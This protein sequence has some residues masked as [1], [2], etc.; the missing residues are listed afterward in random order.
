LPNKAKKC[1]VFNG[2][3]WKVIQSVETIFTLREY[4]CSVLYHLWEVSAN[5]SPRYGEASEAGF[6]KCAAIIPR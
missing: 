6:S 2:G 3:D 1:L 4:L 5:A